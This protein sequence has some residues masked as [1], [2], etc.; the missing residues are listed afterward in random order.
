MRGLGALSVV[1]K[2][3]KATAVLRGAWVGHG[4]PKFLAGPLLT[5]PGF[6][7]NFTFTFKFVRLIYTADKVQPAKF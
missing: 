3:T 7:L 2:S 4:P 5:F 6:V 1:V